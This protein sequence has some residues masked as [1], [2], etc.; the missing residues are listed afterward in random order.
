MLKVALTGG[1]AS[2]KSTAC[3]YFSELG[4]PIIDADLIAKSLL[5]KDRLGYKTAIDIFGNKILNPNNQDINLTVFREVFFSD[6]ELKKQYEDIIHPV[7]FNEISKFQNTHTNTYTIACIPLLFEK[8]KQANFD[9]II[10]VVSADETRL[11][12]T[13]NRDKVETKQ[14][15]SIMDNQIAP[16]DAMKLTDY[17]IYNDSNLNHLHQQIDQLHIKLS[18]KICS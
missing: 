7:V 4:I 18:N 15:E 17:I 13:L 12:R 14:V 3:N 5:E 10:L 9:K 6:P 8:Q 2:G 16:K 1:I 11:T